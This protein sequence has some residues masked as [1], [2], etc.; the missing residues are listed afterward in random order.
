MKLVIEELTPLQQDEAFARGELDLGFTRPLSREQ[1]E[2]F[3]V[4]SLYTEPLLIAMPDHC[5]PPGKSVAR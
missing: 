3:E 2:T 4:R 5:A 1:G